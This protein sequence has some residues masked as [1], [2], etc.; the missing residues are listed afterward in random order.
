MNDITRKKSTVIYKGDYISLRNDELYRDNTFLSSRDVVEHVGSIV[1][2]PYEIS[3]TGEIFF[4]LVRQWRN[5]I[6]RWL[7]EFPAG[8]LNGSENPEDA[9]VRELQEEIGKFPEAIEFHSDFFVA[10]GWC[11]EKMYCFFASKFRESKL[12]SDVDEDI[13]VEKLS[14]IELKEKVKKSEIKDLK[15]IASFYLFCEKNGVK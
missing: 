6:D 9:V 3:S 11:N 1:T 13:K 8:T 7:L 14:L 12:D 15:T 10:P 5:P 2:V 4:Y